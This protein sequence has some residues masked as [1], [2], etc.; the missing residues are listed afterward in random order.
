MSGSHLLPHFTEVGFLFCGSQ[1][2]RGLA[3]V[4]FNNVNH[5]TVESHVYI[6]CEK[7]FHLLMKIS[8]LAVLYLTNYVSE[9]SRFILVFF[10]CLFVCFFPYTLA[11][12]CVDEYP[13][14][15]T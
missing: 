7:K 2:V 4:D 9:Q 1:V 8:R 14:S 13:W 5:C 3:Q 15:H 11:E 12:T 10:V 6:A